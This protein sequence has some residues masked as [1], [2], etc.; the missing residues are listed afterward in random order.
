MTTHCENCSKEI[1]DDEVQQCEI[2]GM[3]GL[4]NCCIAQFDHDCEGKQD[5]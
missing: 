4:G 3:D 1:E 2:C 5:A